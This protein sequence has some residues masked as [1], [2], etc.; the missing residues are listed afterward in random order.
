MGSWKF[1]S[2][3]RLRLPATL[4]IA[5][6]YAV[7]VGVACAGDAREGEGGETSAEVDTSPDTSVEVG[8][9]GDAEI[10]PDFHDTEE[11]ETEAEVDTAVGPDTGPD[12]GSEVGPDTLDTAEP[13]ETDDTGSDGDTATPGPDGLQGLDGEVEPDVADTSEVLE[14]DVPV[15]L[16]CEPALAVDTER[17]ALARQLR[18]LSVTGGTG[19]HRYELVTNTSGAILNAVTGEYVSGPTVGGTD[20]VRVSDLGCVGELV[21]DIHVVA[22]IAVFPARVEL[23][24][25]ESFRPDASGG[26]GSYD[27]ELAMTGTSG[28]TLS[29]ATWAERRFVAGPDEGFETVLVVD[30]ETGETRE[31]PVTVDVDAVP[32]F[33]PPWLFLPPGAVYPVMSVAGS[34][35]LELTVLGE[36]PSYLGE[37]TDPPRRWESDAFGVSRVTGVD[38]FLGAPLVQH[39]VGMGGAGP[40]ANKSGQQLELWTALAPGDLDGDGFAEALVGAGERTQTL[41]ISGGVFLYRGG[42]SGPVA[43]PVRVFSG[44]QRNEQFG[45]AMALGDFDGDGVRD[46]AIGGPRYRVGTNVPGRVVVFS[47]E[48]G[49]F[50]VGPAWSG[51]GL[52]NGDLFGH[53]LAACDFDGDGYDDLAVGAYDSE[54]SVAPVVTN[55]G[56]VVLY[57]GGPAGLGAVAGQT[58]WG[59]VPSESGWVGEVDM[60]FGRVLAAGDLD[61]DGACELA[62]GSPTAGAD[63]GAVWVFAGD[64]TGAGLVLPTPSVVWRGTRAGRFGW[65]MAVGDL[66]GDTTADL[67]IGQPRW[68]TSAVVADN[69]GA[70]RVKSGGPWVAVAATAATEAGPEAFDHTILNPNATS[71]DT[72][73]ELGFRV[74]IGDLSG[75]GRA[76]LVVA[77]IAD[78]ATCTGCVTNAGAVHVLAGRVAGWPVFPAAHSMAAGL[79]TDRQGSAIAVLGVV[80]GSGEAALLS[81][82]GREDSEGADYGRA[83]VLWPRRPGNTYN[84]VQAT[85]EMPSLT[86]GWRVGQALEVLPDLDGDGF[87]EVVVGVPQ[88][89]GP[90]ATGVPPA[91][92]GYFTVHKGTANG[93][94][95]APW[96]TMSTFRRLSGADRWGFDVAALSDFDGDGRVDVAVVG[97]TEDAATTYGTGTISTAACNVA[98]TDCGAVAV[99]GTTTTGVDAQPML[100]HFGAFASQVIEVVTGADVDGDGKTDLIV[101]SRFWDRP[102]TGTGDNGGGFEIVLGKSRAHATSTE[103]TC[104]PARR[105]FGFGAADGFAAAMVGL[106]DLDDD[107]CEELAVGIPGADHLG[108]AGGA[109]EI[110]FGAGVGCAS[111]DVRRVV[112]AAPTANTGLGNAMFARD[113]DGDGLA[114]LVVA[115]STHRVSNLVAGGAWVVPG[116]AL[117]GLAQQAAP[118]EDSVAATAVRLFGVDGLVLNGLA[119]QASNEVFGTGVVLVARRGEAPPM[120]AVA[121]QS[122]VVGGVAVGGVVAVHRLVAEAGQL[123]PEQRPLIVIGAEPH[124]GL[125]TARMAVHETPFGRHLLVGASESSAVAPYS[126]ALWVVPL[127]GL[128]ALESALEVP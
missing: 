104:E 32:A 94:E 35:E 37:D 86:F 113:V 72:N 93:V 69:H 112:I 54:D 30:V 80:D 95:T 52:R 124:G 36:G 77:G 63:N 105:H 64:V 58:L 98:R 108:S 14:P 115:G 81:V 53:A 47:G 87:G 4:W 61:G 2:L 102:T 15:L 127:D 7:G 31:V 76:D 106:G 41:P 56:G 90:P 10:A 89:A 88:G 38:K 67:V 44:E 83:M 3:G 117:A 122:A 18:K 25:N 46:L 13:T 45:A 8:P 74:E 57:R 79:S 118:R 96:Q 107:G 82:L 116:T 123:V 101:G 48:V 62:V 21:V 16:A 120:V 23:R 103:I 43:T 110:F 91:F 84:A 19:A 49:G 111:T 5:A 78:E 71:N 119:G 34:G 51:F 55:Q 99:F 100:M 11:L 29:G 97:R 50:G 6:L 65:A 114:E 42:A 22:P 68:S 33:S 28:A 121:S 128:A 24:P 26:S 40:V 92:S 12:T 39:A 66:N 20:R 85:L 75:D 17:F 109:V 125:P 1:H 9:D 73:D 126:G 60:R 59:R 70:L 27:L